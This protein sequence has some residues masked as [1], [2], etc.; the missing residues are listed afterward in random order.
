MNKWGRFKQLCLVTDQI[1][2][3]YY[4][5]TL[6]DATCLIRL[7]IPHVTV[8]KLNGKYGSLLDRSFS[9]W[10]LQVYV[11]QL[12]RRALTLRLGNEIFWG[13][14][15]GIILVLQICI[16]T[17]SPKDFRFYGK[18]VNVVFS[19]VNWP[20]VLSAYCVVT[21]QCTRRKLTVRGSSD[22]HRSTSVILRYGVCKP[23]LLE[24]SRF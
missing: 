5:S 4:F 7:L 22:M 20:N 10:A 18:E 2:Y 15:D 16:S 19:L 3:S 11:A 9:R 8:L 14:V 6:P 13:S 12:L 24:S 1:N 17:Q 21:T 23:E